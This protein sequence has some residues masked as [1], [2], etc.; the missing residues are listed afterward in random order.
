MAE[1]IIGTIILFVII[2]FVNQSNEKQRQFE[3]EK[4][5]QEKV[6]QQAELQKQQ[7]EDR[8][9]KQI[10]E[11]KN[12]DEK[13]ET[14]KIVVV[15]QREDKFTCVLERQNKTY[16]YVERLNT[17][18]QIDSNL[19]LLKETAN[20]FEWISQIDY[21][22]KQEKNKLELQRQQEAQRQREIEVL[23]NT[24]RNFCETNT[25]YC[26]NIEVLQNQ[27]NVSFN[28]IRR[29]S[30]NFVNQLTKETADQLHSEL[31][32]GVTIIGT[33]DH[34]HKYI[35]SYGNMHQAK[36]L[37][38]YE[39]IP[40]FFDVIDGKAIEIIDYGCGQGI[41]SIIFFEYLASVH[42]GGNMNHRG[43]QCSIDKVKLIESS[44]LALK[45][46]SL[47][48]RAMLNNIWD[49]DVLSI[50]K[51]IEQIN[52]Q[53]LSTSP[54]AIKFHIFSNILDVDD[55]SI[56]S[57]AQKIDNSQKGTNYFICV[58]PKFWKE[59]NHPRNLRLDTFMN[60]FQQRKDVTVFSTRETNINNWKRYERV[61]KVIH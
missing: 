54:T 30:V 7:E 60:Y 37:Q 35:H 2:Y 52:L 27:N 36:L 38:S 58:S 18:F 61:F 33:E 32:S 40:N 47:N 56:V 59:G 15:G 49:V 39:A 50:H 16:A 44:E 57:L 45:R 10:Q 42:W 9:L 28:A 6:R 14:F 25:D 34:L 41:G 4:K 26:D 55:F 31:N 11:Q 48:V 19:K 3:E 21:N 24:Q 23:E 53:D 17:A 29:L 12:E 46:A 5:R 51:T 43:W 20:K 13:Y 1:L 8:R 22:K